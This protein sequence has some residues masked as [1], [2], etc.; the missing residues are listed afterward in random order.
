MSD[1]EEKRYFDEISKKGL[2]HGDFKA[3]F[4][5]GA[6]RDWAKELNT[7]TWGHSIPVSKIET[8]SDNPPGRF[9]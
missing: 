9:G 3:D 6:V 1:G 4:E 2:D 7:D 5:I 8:N